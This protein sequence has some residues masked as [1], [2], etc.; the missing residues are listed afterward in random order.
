M[1]TSVEPDLHT[2]H[3]KGDSGESNAI[4]SILYCSN[5]LYYLQSQLL[6]V[7]MSRILVGLNIFP[8]QMLIGYELMQV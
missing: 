5:T 2:E 1:Q 6:K 7:D 3:L 4:H 8:L